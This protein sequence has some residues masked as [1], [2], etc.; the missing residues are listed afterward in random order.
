MVYEAKWPDGTAGRGKIGGRVLYNFFPGISKR[1]PLVNE[2]G[3]N[4]W[5]NTARCSVQR[6]ELQEPV[7][8][9]GVPT[10]LIVCLVLH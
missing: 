7:Q 5:T 3:Q 4:P 1:W 8:T 10:T 6:I 9:C 2:F